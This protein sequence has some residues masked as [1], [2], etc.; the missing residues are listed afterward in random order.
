MNCTQISCGWLL[1]LSILLM[2]FL[3]MPLARAGDEFKG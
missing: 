2:N 1:F 3:A